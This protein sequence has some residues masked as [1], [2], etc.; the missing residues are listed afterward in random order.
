MKYSKRVIPILVLVIMLLSLTVNAMD[1]T[2]T[3]TLD[4]FGGG[5]IV[6]Q[7]TMLQKDYQA[8]VSETGEDP[9]AGKTTYSYTGED[10]GTYI[11]TVETYSCENVSEIKNSLKSIVSCQNSAKLFREV[12]YSHQYSIFGT[13][14]K[15]H[16]VINNS[17]DATNIIKIASDNGIFI[18]THNS[19]ANNYFSSQE[20]SVLF[21]MKDQ[22]TSESMVVNIYTINYG[23]IIGAVVFIGLIVLIVV[24]LKK[25]KNFNR[26]TKNENEQF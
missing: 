6:H 24:I 11:Y 19:N 20:N 10:G 21:V 26:P 18:K 4:S 17:E 5:E 1:E 8:Y 25:H 7:S 12:S 23:V 22:T 15:F 9:F 3:I 14:D 2:V 13:L 16:L